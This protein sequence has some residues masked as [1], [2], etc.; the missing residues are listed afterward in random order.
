MGEWCHSRTT[1]RVCAHMQD[2]QREARLCT[3]VHGLGEVARVV[4]LCATTRT[5]TRSPTPVPWYADST[6]QRRPGIHLGRA[7]GAQR[8]E[9]P[10]THL[11]RAWAAQ[12]QRA[13][14]SGH[15]CWTRCRAGG[16]RQPHHPGGIRQARVSV[17]RGNRTSANFFLGCGELVGAVGRRDSS[18][19]SAQA[20]RVNP[21]RRPIRAPSP[22]RAQV[23]SCCGLRR[24]WRS[25]IP[26]RR[27]AAMTVQPCCRS[28]ISDVSI[29]SLEGGF[30]QRDTSVVMNRMMRQ[31]RVRVG[32]LRRL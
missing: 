6:P 5:V 14:P 21:P 20:V 24:P 26:S 16:T 27:R 19:R 29:S 30:S 15:R 18:G 22:G 10:R 17:V 1:I 2:F 4:S 8:V 23:P 13:H 28:W 7:C 9:F 3:A 25:I 11:Y 32:H 31:N 12:P